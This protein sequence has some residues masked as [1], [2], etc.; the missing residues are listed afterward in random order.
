[1]NL[2]ANKCRT[3]DQMKPDRIFT[4]ILLA[5]MATSFS[6]L[7]SPVEVTAIGLDQSRTIDSLSDDAPV[8]RIRRE[9]YNKKRGIF[10][11][12]ADYITQTRNEAMK[13]L[14]EISTILSRQFV[15]EKQLNRSAPMAEM[16]LSVN[17][18]TTAAPYIVTQEELQRILRRNYRALVRIFNM[19]SRKAIEDSNN[20]VRVL[21]KELKDAVRPFF[22]RNTTRRSA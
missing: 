3:V 13:S 18:S 12:L 2:L 15:P 17:A 19:E 4:F 21:R 9:T 5:A 8:Y 7:L 10:S 14:N 20:N 6:F 16:Q 1:M 11:L 22:E